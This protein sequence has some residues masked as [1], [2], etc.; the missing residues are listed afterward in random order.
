MQN[1]SPIWCPK[2]AHHTLGL[3][4][5]LVRRGAGV[6]TPPVRLDMTMRVREFGA[7]CRSLTIESD[8]LKKAKAFFAKEGNRP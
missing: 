2:D 4:I 1:A 8:I 6:F 5:S 3:W 7:Q